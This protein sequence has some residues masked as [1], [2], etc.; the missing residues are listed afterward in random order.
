MKLK[1][2]ILAALV[3]L[4]FPAINGRSSEP[5][6]YKDTVKIGL[7]ITNKN[8]VAA[9]N[10]AEMA[11]SKANSE[12]GCNGNPFKLVVRSMEGPWGTGSKEAVSMIFDEEVW[13]ILGSNDGR[14]A[15]LAEQ[16]SAKT[17]V[18]FLSAWAADPTLSQAFVP[19]Y[20]NC[21]PNNSQQAEILINEICSR[22]HFNKIAAICENSYDAGFALKSFVNK[23]TVNG[24]T[25]PVEFRYNNSDPESE[26]MIDKIISVNP[27]CIALFGTPIS[28]T[29]IIRLL[30][31]KG[32]RIPVYGSLSLL[33][34]NELMEGRLSVYEGINLIS[35]KHWLSREGISFIE[36]FRKL[37][38]KVPGAV[39]A[40]AYDG[41]NIIIESIR[42][43]SPD[44]EKVQK[45]MANINIKGVTGNIMFDERGNRKG[46]FSLMIIKDG[47]P[48]PVQ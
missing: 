7:L 40:Y 35:S 43:A 18:V 12:G 29:K 22:K 21:V 5:H 23:I 46:P 38:G 3:L 4:N 2:L 14:N 32:V 25:A 15:H 11:I 39:A 33:D 28:S 24:T 37:Y 47:N 26:K 31:D 8:T 13:A 19:W 42:I 48:V 17:R 44:R 6:I 36:E 45:A 10:G 16:V 41:M 1:C 9:K 34:E 30:K 20:F 27:D